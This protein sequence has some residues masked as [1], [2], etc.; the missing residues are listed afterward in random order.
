MMACMLLLRMGYAETALKA[1][2][3]YN[4][5]RVCDGRGLT[6]TSQKKWVH[7]YEN[8]LRSDA[9]PM[10]HLTLSSG[11]SSHS[12]TIQ[13]LVIRNAPTGVKPPLLRLRIS[14]L[15]PVTT[16]KLTIFETTGHERFLVHTVVHGCVKLEFCR[17]RYA[18]CFTSKKHFRV[19][20]HTMYARPPASTGLVVFNRSA[21]DWVTRDRKLRKFPAA[22]DLEMRAQV[23]TTA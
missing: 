19:W 12:L 20:F 3:W 1:I 7:Y 5:E 21:M 15:D 13:E 10:D 18:N 11:G 6:V 17:E 4:R 8:L 23:C 22:F 14:T 9:S 16:Q 2:E